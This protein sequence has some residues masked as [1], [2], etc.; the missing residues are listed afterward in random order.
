MKP[1]ILWIA[2]LAAAF[3]AGTVVGA[4]GFPGSVQAEQK[5]GPG[6][7]QSVPENFVLGGNKQFAVMNE[8]LTV[9]RENQVI[10]QNIERNTAAI[11]A[12]PR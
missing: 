7:V 10:L 5:F 11:A 3:A 2:A 6:D 1:R 9:T 4:L 8:L 12:R